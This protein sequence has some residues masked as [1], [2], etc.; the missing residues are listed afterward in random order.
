MT[1]IQA[2][3]KEANHE[4]NH[5]VNGSE[6]GALVDFI[7]ITID[8]RFDSNKDYSL[9][10]S[11]SVGEL[12]FK[13][14]LKLSKIEV[15][16]EDTFLVSKEI[17]DGERTVVLNEYEPHCHKSLIDYLEGFQDTNQWLQKWISSKGLMTCSCEG[18][19]PY[20]FL[21]LL[22]KLVFKESSDL[23]I[24]LEI[25]SFLAA[26]NYDNLLC[27]Q[28]EALKAEIQN[29]HSP[30]VAKIL[31]FPG[32]NDWY[33]AYFRDCHSV[34][35]ISDAKKNQTKNGFLIIFGHNFSRGR[36]G[37]SE[38][39]FFHINEIDIK[40][41]VCLGIFSCSIAQSDKTALQ[42]VAQNVKV[43]APYT[44]VSETVALLYMH[45]VVSAKSKSWNLA[46]QHRLGVLL[47]NTITTYLH[48][49][50]DFIPSDDYDTIFR[51]MSK[52]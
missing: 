17:Y 6:K 50:I 51:R 18:Y 12:S 36:I 52:Q 14:Y 19:L 33:K 20:D 35:F 10:I 43:V 49:K 47:L 9:L 26:Y 29:V 42:K 27:Q 16:S 21:I 4:V 28:I 25:E 8:Y 40:N 2:N 37:P 3:V 34:E 5:E 7:R 30:T 11:S 32:A 38:D 48:D 44:D 15:D 22:A 13:D 24:G 45:G 1:L 41:L 31:Y 23:D 46:A 39:R